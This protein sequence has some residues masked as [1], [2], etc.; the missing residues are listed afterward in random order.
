MV[1]LWF[2]GAR[3]GKVIHQTRHGWAEAGFAAAHGGNASSTFPGGIQVIHAR[4]RYE[5]VP[6]GARYERLWHSN[7][8]LWAHYDCI[9][10]GPDSAI[11]T[12][13][14]SDPGGLRAGVW[15][16][17]IRIDGQVVMQ[18]SLTITGNVTYWDA[19]GYFDGCYG[20]Q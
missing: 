6:T 20:K 13:T 19:P 14:L 2:Q 4:W 12:L 16:A 17:T 5:H 10:P 15:Q 3:R 18:E 1:S 8:E 11:E 9:W 7:R